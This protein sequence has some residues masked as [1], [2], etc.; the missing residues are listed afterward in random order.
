MSVVVRTC[1]PP[2][3]RLQLTVDCERCCLA[4]SGENTGAEILGTDDSMTVD[5]PPR[6]ALHP[7]LAGGR[8]ST[9]L[10]L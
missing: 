9:K 4:E 7:L 1:V 5:L 8:M 10:C 2:A 3:H 6:P